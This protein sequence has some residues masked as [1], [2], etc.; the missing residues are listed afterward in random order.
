MG[1]RA[2]QA[3]TPCA[4]SLTSSVQGRLS[5]KPPSRDPF[6]SFSQREAVSSRRNRVSVTETAWLEVAA[7]S[8]CPGCGDWGRR[9]WGMVGWAG[10]TQGH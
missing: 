3:H 2:G 8:L 5:P 6:P 7:T 9:G 4:L 10:D 1:P